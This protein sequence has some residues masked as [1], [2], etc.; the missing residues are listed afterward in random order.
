MRIS[1]RQ[2]FD[3]Q[4]DLESA[5]GSPIASYRF[6]QKLP[7]PCFY[8]LHTASGRQIAGFQMSDHA[9]HRGLWFTIKFI[10]KSNFWEESPPFGIQRTQTQPNCE[11][12]SP[13]A[14][15]ISHKLRW[16]S[17][18]TDAVIDEDRTINFAVHADGTRDIDWRTSLLPLQDLLLDRTPFTAWGGYGGL[19]F[20][21]GREVHNTSYLLPDGQTTD[22]IIG[23]PHPWALLRGSVDGDADAK[24]SLGI[25][26]H[27]G[28]LRSPQPWYAKSG[29]SYDF[30]NAAFLFHEPLSVS[31][32]QRL[33]FHYR[34][35]YRDGWW[36]APEFA[37]LADE[38]THSAP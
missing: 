11:F 37:K 13:Q 29:Q 23:Q 35:L 10:N 36:E 1:F 26:N 28:N 2:I 6:D 38:F 17:Q 14:V 24:I 31:R 20:R 3:S 34:I 12:I 7:K 21:A 16:I 25:I 27:P 30:M 15:S 22:A 5:D 33:D 9:W 32:G 8:P 19:A 4:I 18:A